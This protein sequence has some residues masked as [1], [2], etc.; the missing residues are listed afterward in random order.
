MC[1][2]LFVLQLSY[3]CVTGAILNS[4]SLAASFVPVYFQHVSTRSGSSVKQDK[5]K[6]FLLSFLKEFL[7]Y[8]SWSLYVAIGEQSALEQSWSTRLL[9]VR[10]FS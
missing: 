8:P 6:N 1:E 2:Y 4:L 3:L 9:A 10:L 7:K 5:G